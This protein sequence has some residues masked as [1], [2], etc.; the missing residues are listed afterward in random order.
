MK[1]LSIDCGIKNLAYCLYNTESKEIEEWNVV[2]I[3]PYPESD[4]SPEHSYIPELCIT[5]FETNKHL[6]ECDTVIIEKQPPRNAKMRVTEGSIYTYFVLRG[7]LDG[8]IGKVETYSPK[9]KLKGVL[10]I[11]GKSS[12]SKR[13]KVA[14]Q[15]VTEI[16]QLQLQKESTSSELEQNKLD[17]PD[18]P[19][20]SDKPNK[21]L[22]YFCEHK[23]RDDLADTYLMLLAYINHQALSSEIVA[24]S[25]TSNSSTNIRILAKKPKET[26]KIADYT[27][28]NLK[29]VLREQKILYPALSE[30][31][32]FL[33]EEN[34]KELLEKILE[35][36]STIEECIHKLKL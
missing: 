22:R 28:G 12:Y 32:A 30:L 8:I 21:W 20:K 13:K 17:K 26:V 10:G 2:N 29:Y 34:N 24:T 31:S 35:K 14:I 25:A 15:K 9:H 18:K 6:L 1:I 5:F 3:A 16:L 23:K 4:K 27:L 36:Y 19:D 11:S 7:R 33:N